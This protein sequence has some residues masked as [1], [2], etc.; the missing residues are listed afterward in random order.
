MSRLGK[1]WFRLAS[2][3]PTPMMDEIQRSQSRVLGVE[4]RRTRATG[5]IEREA[6][7]KQAIGAERAASAE[8]ARLAR[9]RLFIIS[10]RN[11][12]KGKNGNK[13]KRKG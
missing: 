5:G 10:A 2:G 6:M 3:L 11:A 7:L 9:R 4:A 8:T 12:A 1:K 13:K